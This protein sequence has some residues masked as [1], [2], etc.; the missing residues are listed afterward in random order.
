MNGRQFILL[1]GVLLAPAAVAEEPSRQWDLGSIQVDGS[2]PEPSARFIYVPEGMRFSELRLRA[3]VAA[4]DGVNQLVIRLDGRVVHSLRPQRHA[5]LDL[6]LPDLGPGFHRIDFTGK[7]SARTADNQ[8]DLECPVVTTFPF[9]LNDLVLHYQQERTRAPRIAELPDGLYNASHPDGGY[10]TVIVAPHSAAAFTAAARVAGWLNT[11]G[12]IR[13]QAGTAPRAGGFILHIRHDETLE[14]PARITLRAAEADTSEAQ[15]MLSDTFFL[16]LS[17]RLA[18]LHGDR[19]AGRDDQT[20]PDIATHPAA[21]PYALLELR[22]RSEEALEHAVHALLNRDYRRQ[23]ATASA[24]ISD[25]V[26]EPAW[27]TLRPLRTLSDF[28]VDDIRMRGLSERTLTLQYPLHWIPVGIPEGRIRLRAQA[29]LPRGTRVNF[30]LDDALAGSEPLAF[31]G[32]ADIQRTVPVTGARVPEGNWLSLRVDAS[33]DT[34]RV[35]DLGAEGDLWIDSKAS[36]LSF[37][38]REKTGVLGVLPRMVSHPRIAIDT[39]GDRSLAALLA[40]MRTQAATVGNRSVPYDVQIGR[41]DSET[42]DAGPLALRIAI[43]ADEIDTRADTFAGRVAPGYLREAVWLHSRDDGTLDVI[44]RTG[45]AF[46][47]FARHWPNAAHRIPDG[48][49]DVVFSTVDGSFVVLHAQPRVT[50]TGRQLTEDQLRAGI[51]A[52]AVIFAIFV[53]LLLLYLRRRTRA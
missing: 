29:G 8:A 15:Q 5:E 2:T 45:E 9:A 22:Y 49:R 33:L 26:D 48:A 40:L 28:G 7:P 10:G 37:N 12:N 51:I 42:Q 23:L 1:L 41:A 20:L 35:C 24:D 38:Y 43:D 18:S 46:A 39:P 6:R 4:D 30:W 19:A 31:L 44:A 32:S 21:S 14:A 36:T 34:P 17:E 53:I 25:A 13:W 3:E 52:A 16:R 27:A 50:E 11:T 47:G